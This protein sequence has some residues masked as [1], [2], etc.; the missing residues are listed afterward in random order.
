LEGLVFFHVMTE[1]VVMD[2]DVSMQ[3]WC[4]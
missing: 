2:I 3:V 1:P 4:W